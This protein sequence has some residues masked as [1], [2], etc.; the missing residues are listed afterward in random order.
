MAVPTL[1]GH[2]LT[3]GTGRDLLV[4]G[5]SL[6]TGVVA[7]W[8]RCAELVADRAGVDVLGWDLPG[9][10]DG[11]PLDEPFT[12]SDLARAVGELVER[13]RP[14]ARF[15]H[16]GVSVGGATGLHLAI[17]GGG[18]LRGSAV[19]CSDAQIG[20]PQAWAERA[21]VVRGSGTGA[22]VDGSL[23]RWFAPGVVRESPAT[24]ERLLETLRAADDASYA[25]VCEALAGHDVRGQLAGIEVPVLVLG[26]RHDAVCTPQA[27]QRLADAVPGARLV[28]VEGAAHLAPA[29]RPAEV[30]AALAD[31]VAACG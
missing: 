11:E 9:H 7:L 29:E 21:G 2:R 28:V 15:W 19:L 3:P 17:A 20:T 27:Q 8:E 10:G 1:T 24:V 14:G 12:L 4:V 23:Q 6:G 26:G 25:R 22:M 16:A 13:E 30:A 5:P 31:W 18:R